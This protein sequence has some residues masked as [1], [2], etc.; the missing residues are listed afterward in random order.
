MDSIVKSI[1]NKFTERSKF[2]K[3]K[4]G[5]D[6][7]RDDLSVLEWLTHFQEE[8]MD[9]IL[10]AE[11]L[12]QVLLEKDLLNKEYKMNLPEHI[13]PKTIKNHYFQQ[14]MLEWERIV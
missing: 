5:T 10:Y 13:D 14:Q 8:L 3:E 11:K 6:L 1:I 7:D 12:K 2:G 9:G 4:Y